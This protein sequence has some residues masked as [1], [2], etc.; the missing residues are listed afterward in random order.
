MNKKTSV[1]CLIV[2]LCAGLAWYVLASTSLDPAT[3]RSSSGDAVQAG[4]A[5]ETYR[6][7]AY[8]FS[9]DLPRNTRVESTSEEGGTVRIVSDPSSGKVFQIYIQETGDATLN[10]T[11]SRIR[12]DIPDLSI[13]DVQS[14][15]IS[16]GATGTAFISTDDKG[17]KREVWFAFRGV[18]YQISAPIE[19]DTFLRSILNTWKF[20]SNP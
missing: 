16:T 18:L 4:S 2:A 5:I 9:I 6:D 3:L 10:I 11:E 20:I 13:R 12:Q 17:E 19:S 1:I 14:V 15:E 8:S 7:E